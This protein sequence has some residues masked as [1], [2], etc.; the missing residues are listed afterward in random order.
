MRFNRDALEDLH[1]A[2]TEAS[3][4]VSRLLEVLPDGCDV[5]A[6]LDYFTPEVAVLT[7]GGAS[8]RFPVVPIQGDVINLSVALDTLRDVAAMVTGEDAMGTA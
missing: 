4:S 5:H 8:H 7:F 3:A 6:N 1:D 2:L